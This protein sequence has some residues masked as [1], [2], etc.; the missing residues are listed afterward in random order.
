MACSVAGLT[1]DASFLTNELTFVMNLVLM[2]L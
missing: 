2:N 1:S